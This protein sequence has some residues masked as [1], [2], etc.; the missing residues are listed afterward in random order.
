MTPNHHARGYA[1]AAIALATTFTLAGAAAAD[2]GRY[3]VKF[4]DHGRGRA[5]LHAAGGRIALDL[6]PQGAAAAILPDAAVEALARNPHVEYIEV[7]PVREAQAEIPPYG[8]SM[9]EADGVSD[10]AAANTTVCI[11]D[12]GYFAAHPDLPDDPAKVTGAGNAATGDWR[13]DGCEHG[14]HVAGTIAAL[15]N[16]I[17][18]IGVLPTAQVHLHII[19]IFDDRCS[20]TYAS[21]LIDALNRCRAAGANVVNMSLGGHSPSDTERAAFEQ[22]YRDGMLTVAAAGNDGGRRFLYPA[23]YDAVVSVGAVD[24]NRV[25]ASFST[26]NDQV[27]LVGPG[28]RVLSTVPSG[29]GYAYYSGTSMATPHVAGVAALVWSHRPELTNVQLRGLLRASSQDLGARGRDE[30][31][32][33]GL[34][35]AAAALA[36]AIC[37]PTQPTETSCSDEFDNDCDGAIDADDPNCAPPCLGPNVRCT[38][39]AECCVGRCK[40]P[41]FARTCR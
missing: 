25:I 22:A 41:S 15:L 5:A 35:R 40:G 6:A 30:Y 16:G 3:L 9:V 33:Y 8:I 29:T 26:H 11:V 17:G 1:I 36:T 21:S 38:R 4:R 14:T 32:G 34:V 13:R 27:E 18:V 31:Y 19:K 24:E 39:D 20:W 37:K 7:D 12:S 2:P 23:S 10:A 28:V